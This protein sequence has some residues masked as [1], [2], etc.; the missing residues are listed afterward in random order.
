MFCPTTMF[1]VSDMCKRENVWGGDRALCRMRVCLERPFSSADITSALP[2]VH[3]EW[4]I[5]SGYSHFII[6][7][8]DLCSRV[9]VR[10]EPIN[11]REIY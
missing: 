6:W 8:P 7:W 11:Y 2:C 1:L 10:Y 9:Q 5:Q 4:N 3:L